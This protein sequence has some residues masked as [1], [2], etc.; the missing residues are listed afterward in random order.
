[1]Y[2]EESL[3]HVVR[4]LSLLGLGL[5]IVLP[6]ALVSY[7]AVSQEVGTSLILVLCFLASLLAIFMELNERDQALIV[8]AYS[9]IMAGPLSQAV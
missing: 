3:S 5:F 2:D 1:M 6:L 4:A 9:A 7:H 8:F